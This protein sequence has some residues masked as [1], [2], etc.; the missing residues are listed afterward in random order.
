MVAACSAGNLYTTDLSSVNSYLTLNSKPYQSWP[1]DYT[2]YTTAVQ[3]PISTQLLPQHD[4]SSVKLNQP[5]HDEQFNTY[6]HALP[7][8]SAQQWTNQHLLPQVSTQQW[9]NQHILPEVSTQQWTN[10]HLLPQIS[11]QQWTNQHALPEISTQQWTNQHLLPQVSTQQWTNQ[12]LSLSSNPSTISSVPQYGDTSTKFYQGW[13]SDKIHTTP[14]VSLAH[15][16]V[17]SAPVV[18]HHHHEDVSAKYAHHWPTTEQLHTPV[19]SLAPVSPTTILT[20]PI[21]VEKQIPIIVPGIWF[22]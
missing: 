8:V 17:T 12:Q 14:V 16:S 10:Q 19:V 9:T 1:N 18:H 13:P 6:L 21:A 15:T 5:W 22:M 20:Q 11:T 7:Q 2:S 3:S 4:E